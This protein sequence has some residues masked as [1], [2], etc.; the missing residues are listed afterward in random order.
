MDMQY[1]IKKSTFQAI[2]Y[3][4]NEYIFKEKDFVK[5]PLEDR[6]SIH[7]EKLEPSEFKI[8]ELARG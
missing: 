6:D 5:E 8:Y 4:K 2:M 3:S 1:L 7:F